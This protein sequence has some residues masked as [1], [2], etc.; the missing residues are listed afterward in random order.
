MS[1]HDG[2][3]TLRK[4]G[5]V[6]RQNPQMLQVPDRE[7]FI[8]YKDAAKLT[9]FMKARGWEEDIRPYVSKTTTKGKWKRKAK[10]KK[11]GE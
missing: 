4:E 10:V 9:R 3:A 11:G 7:S 8:T 5:G 1:W 2:Q 6:W